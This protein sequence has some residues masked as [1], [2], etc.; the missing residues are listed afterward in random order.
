MFKIFIEGTA[1]GGGCVTL[2][3]YKTLVGTTTDP[4]NVTSSIESVGY[5]RPGDFRLNVYVNGAFIGN[6]G[7]TLWLDAHLTFEDD[8]PPLK[9]DCVNGACVGYTMYNTP[10]IYPTLSACEQA[11]GTGCSGKCVSNSDW[12]QIEGLSGQLKNRNCS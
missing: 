4:S 2:P 12:A 5:C 8:S 1:L 6:D 10:G 9:Y 7:G 11:C 3:N